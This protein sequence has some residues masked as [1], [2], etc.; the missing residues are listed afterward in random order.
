MSKSVVIQGMM[1]AV[2]GGFLGGIVGGPL[3][4]IIAWWSFATFSDPEKGDLSA[5]VLVLLLG[6]AGALTAGLCVATLGGGYLAWRRDRGFVTAF[7]KGATAVLTFGL[8]VS[9][10]FG[11]W[12]C[13]PL[14]LGG[15]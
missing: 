6:V 15:R 12:L 8:G 3:T 7:Y 10:M 14:V 11:P 1:G 9:L 4:F 5:I 13:G 2:I